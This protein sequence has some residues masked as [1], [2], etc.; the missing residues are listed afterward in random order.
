[1]PLFNKTRDE[2]IRPDVS[3][4]DAVRDNYSLLSCLV[5]PA[6]LAVYGTRRQD[7]SVRARYWFDEF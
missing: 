4:R 6:P 7:F 3:L 2:L 5:R 1:M